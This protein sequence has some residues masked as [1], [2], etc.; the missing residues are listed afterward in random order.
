MWCDSGY[1]VPGML[2]VR[3]SGTSM[4]RNLLALCVCVC[5]AFPNEVIVGKGEFELLMDM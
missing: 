2:T 5:S 1:S 3:K 4:I